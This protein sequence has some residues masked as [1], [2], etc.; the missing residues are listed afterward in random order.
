MIVFAVMLSCCIFHSKDIEIKPMLHLNTSM[1]TSDIWGLDTDQRGK[2][3][4]T[5]S[6][7]KTARLWD[8]KT[9]DLIRIF[10]PP[11]DTGSEGMLY[12]GAISP[13][14]KTAAVGGYTGYD[15]TG[16]FNV[17]IFN[18]K[19][20]EL[21]HELTNIDES[22][23][24]IIYS[25]D[26]KFLAVCQG[27]KG[28]VSVF[29]T[30]GW[31]EI[32]L[33]GY[34]DKVFDAVFYK[35]MFVTVSYDGKIR[36]YDMGKLPRPVKSAV[37]TGGTQ[38]CSV[39]VNPDGSKIAVGYS[40]ENRIQVL[41][42]E[43]LGL[44]YEPDCTGGSQIYNLSRVAWSLDG[45]YL[46]AGGNYI[47]KIK[48]E[49]WCPI[50]MWSEG[51]KGEYDESPAAYGSVRN[52]KVLPDSTILYSGYAPD[53][54]KMDTNGKKLIYKR[55]EI[56]PMNSSD[57]DFLKIKDDGEGV[58][59]T[60]VGGIP[61]SFSI[62]DRKLLEGES[63]YSNN[64]RPVEVMEISDFAYSTAPRLNGKILNILDDY[65]HSRCYAVNPSGESFL[66]G[67][68]WDIYYLGKSGDIIWK[69]QVNAAVYSIGI[70]QTREIFAAAVGDGTIRWYRLRDGMELLSL[71]I[72]SATKKWVLW[73]PSGYYDCSTGGDNL[74][75][76]HINNGLE[77]A[78]DFYPASRFSEKF[79]RPDVIPLI[80]DHYNDESFE[81]LAINNATNEIMTILPPVVSI[82]SPENGATVDNPR[83][84]LVINVRTPLNTKV[85]EI[86]T[87][88][89]GRPIANKT[90]GLTVTPAGREGET[91]SIA[92]TLTGEV[93]EISVLARNEN[94][95]SEPA[96]IKVT[97]RKGGSGEEFVIKPKLYLL[98]I[99]VS[100]YDNKD[101]RLKYPAKDAGD[102]AQAMIPQKG[103]LYRDIEEKIL[104]NENATKDNILD[105]LDWIQKETTSKDVAMI[106]LSGHGVDD[107]NGFFYYLP[108]NTDLDKLKRTAVPFTDIKN[109]IASIAGKTVF[110]VDACHSGN[111][112]GTRKGIPDI[113]GIVNELTSAENGAVVFTSS[114]G[115]QYSLESD[116]WANGAFTKALVEGLRGKAD[117]DKTGRITINMI[118]LYVSERVKE[119]TKGA[120]TPS[121][122]KPQTIPDFPVAIEKK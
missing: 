43:S 54:G 17:Y 10:R 108:V 106:F 90:K 97:Y 69:K 14:G 104:T 84:E 22:P 61:Y 111:I 100:L 16:T 88:V 15:W 110:F 116:E 49:W 76:W 21:T 114:T 86:K 121:T 75:G 58:S 46:Y 95:W 29:N 33:G 34:G 27:R 59:F 26:G 122:T 80:F 25:P 79:Y 103:G 7:D 67:A 60:P 119:L 109:T 20:G 112:M 55:G 40:D 78:A 83:V 44:L 105:A 120:Q 39:A 85:I 48:N 18:A 94:S 37:L 89:N 53:W 19:T 23:Q 71:Y 98:A 73:T 117:Y 72:N 99:G 47:V 77:R 74:I 38:P 36:I 68:D 12:A 63:I 65:E 41:D 56:F 32:H 13:D 115:N 45:N 57:S 101:I 24:K 50:R 8:T 35:K 30:S 118:D 81:N 31:S 9:G 1:H 87:L 107:A 28:G 93:N 11:I 62:P 4:L 51:G 64:S 2:Y 91:E 102:F 113:N 6:Q 82:L 5:A 3:V 70:A 96:T 52:I 92:L 42:F 66:L